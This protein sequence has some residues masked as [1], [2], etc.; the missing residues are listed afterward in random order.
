[1]K[2]KICGLTRLYDIDA[3]NVIKPDYIGF[4]FAK[5]TR[6][7]SADTAQLLKKHLGEEIK[8]VGVFVNEK[9]DKI[10]QICDTCGLDLIQLHGDENETFIFNLKKRISQEIIK[11]IRVQNMEQMR[12]V[13]DFPCE[14]I[15]LDTYDPHQYGGSGKS[16]DW[17]MIP[18]M[19]KPFFLAGGLHIN[20]VEQ[21][22][23]QCKPFCLDI[24]SGVEV[25][26]V[27][28]FQKMKNIVEKI[29][30]GT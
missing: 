25:N 9:L 15:L 22:M 29:R 3:V 14:Y 20:N 12:Q 27:K 7:V 6:Q 28:D 1:M 2:V 17:T 19:N 30:E 18:P 13:Q 16:F 5:S 26:G 23:S 10:L 8:T 4:V 11:A 24:S 21:A